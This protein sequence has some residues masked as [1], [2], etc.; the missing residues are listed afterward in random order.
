MKVSLNWLK[1]YVDINIPPEEL[2]EKLTMVGLEASDVQTIGNGWFN[3][4]IGEVI[5]LERHPNADRLRLATVTLGDEQQIVVCG[6]PNVAVGQRIAFAKLGAKLFDGHNGKYIELKPAKI[7]G[8]H[9]EGMVCSERELGISD[10]H[11]GIMVLAEDAPIGTP[12][13]DY[14]GDT[15]FDIT[16]TPNRPD[17]LNMVGIAREVAAITGAEVRQPEVGYAELD[18]D[19]SEMITIE[20]HDPDLCARYCGGII[21]DIKIGPSPDWM[22]RRLLAAGMR[23][24]NNIVDIT[25]F[26]ML[27]YGQPLHAFDYETIGGQ[28]IIVRRGKESEWMYTLDGE[29][30]TL[31]G[32]MLVIADTEHPVA[33]AGVMGGA[34]SEVTEQTTTI[35]LESANF[36]NVSIRRTSRGLGLISEASTRFDK[37]LSRELPMVGVRRAIQLMVEL[38]GGKATKGI[39][40]AYPVDLGSREPILLTEQKAEQV[41]GVNFG[42]TRIKQTLESLGFECEETL[43]SSLSVVVPYWR[44]DV[45][46]VEDLI[47]EVARIIGYDDI[48]MTMLSGEIPQHEPTP[49][50]STKNNIR[51]I[52]VGS[53]MQ[54]IINY[55]MTSQDVLDKSKC[56]DKFGIPLRMANPLSREQEFLRVSLRGG[57]LNSYAANERFQDKGIMLFEVGKVY[58]PRK[59]DLPDEREM[60]C[61]VIGGPQLS[62]SLFGDKGAYDF[63]YAKGILLTMFDRLGVEVTF[64]SAN[65]ELLLSGKTAT[66]KT[67]GKEVGIVG[68]LHPEI[69]AE[70]EISAESVC[71]FEIEI[72]KIVDSTERLRTFTSIPRFPSTDRDLAL[73]VD[74]SLPA[75]KITDIILGFHQVKEANIFDVYQGKQVPEGKKSLAFALR[76]QSMERTLTDEEVDKIQ[77]KILAKL[78]REV[79][80]I[81]RH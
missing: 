22:Q 23:P 47:E 44:T 60:L 16:V 48:P 40:D 5:G 75:Q 57:L 19:T 59:D 3:I 12:L 33:L 1:D 54:E 49:L 14:M 56:P 74:S 28:K 31:S 53:G 38:A 20:I 71:M 15:V 55:S 43:E 17:C 21:R 36:N 10:S 72:D 6:A 35:L 51:D 45:M 30:R 62:Q 29:E 69:A 76:Y 26:V 2:A 68:E 25:N 70:F 9:S 7:R 80:A 18:T 34:D 39:V 50:T 65:D 77:S 64:E 13:A 46:I 79:G 27:E 8:V 41:L 11:E 78:E 58:L 42:I 73:V 81:L 61:G 52:L 66:V 37:G 4:L 32:D 24:I 63:F 67:D